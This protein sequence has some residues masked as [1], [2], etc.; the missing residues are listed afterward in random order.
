MR[1]LIVDDEPVARK[2][3]REE[4]EALGSVEIVGEA[5]DGEMALALISST[6]PDLVF[7]DL[8]MPILGGFEMLDRLQGG[9]LPVFVIVTAYDQYA[10]RAFEAG[11]IDYLLKPVGE[12]RLK[13]SL[14]RAR[15]L[16]QSPR[17]VA[18]AVVQLQDLAPQPANTAGARV[19]KII[20]KLND[21]YFLLNPNE[22]L[23]FQAD[24]DITWIITM[25][26][27]YMATQNLKALEERLIHANFRRIHRNALVNINQIRKMSMITSQRW[28]VTL[29]NAQEFVVSKRL[30]KNVRD[31]LTW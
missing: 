9:Q 4:L 25:K 21:E 3:L 27:R 19:R 13:Q 6:R 7:L 26:Q 23:A 29:N 1:T 12:A 28:L 24:G 10:I 2:V 15:R 18:E 16:A 30:A 31:V 8:Q 20:G 17:E 11:A 5:G 22:V 14:D